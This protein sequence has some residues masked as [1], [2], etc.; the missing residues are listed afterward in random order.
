MS[1]LAMEGLCEF[2]HRRHADAY[3]KQGVIVIFSWGQWACIFYNGYRRRIAD[4]GIRLLFAPQRNKG[5]W[6]L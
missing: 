2:Y 4:A 3:L 1:A 5:R 6:S